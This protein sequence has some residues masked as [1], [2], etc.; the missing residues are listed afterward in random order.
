MAFNAKLSSSPQNYF[1]FY[2]RMLII[3]LVDFSLVAFLSITIPLREEAMHLCPPLLPAP[4][5]WQVQL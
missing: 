1:S 5:A 4:P 2:S 3:A